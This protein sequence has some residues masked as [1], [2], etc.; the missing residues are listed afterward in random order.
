MFKET[1]T[2]ILNERGV[3][4]TNFR[5]WKKIDQVEAERGE[6]LKKLRE[7]IKTREEYFGLLSH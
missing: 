6:S 7:K 3:K 2:K 5:D 4:W 1:V